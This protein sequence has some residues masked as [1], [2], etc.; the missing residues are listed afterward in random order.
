MFNAKVFV[1]TQAAANIVAVL[2]SMYILIPMVNHMREFL[3]HC[4][5]FS[6]GTYIETDGHFK[7]D[8]S[9]KGFCVYSVIVSSISIVASTIQCVLKIRLFY[10]SLERFVI[11][12]DCFIY[13]LTLCLFSNFMGSFLDFVVDALV[14]IM[15]LISSILTSIGFYDWCH[16]VMQRFDS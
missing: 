5:L 3:G 9:S 8:W 7:P 13:L 12:F 2:A 6:C 11:V 14:L 10:L 16:C 4:A 1:V 15:V